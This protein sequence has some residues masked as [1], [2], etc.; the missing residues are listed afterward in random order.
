MAGDILRTVNGGYNKADVLSK[1]DAYTVLIMT[2]DENLM[3]D[4]AVNAELLRIKEMPLRQNKKGMIFSKSGLATT[5]L[6]VITKGFPLMSVN[7]EHTSNKCSKSSQEAIV[8]TC[9][10][11]CFPNLTPFETSSS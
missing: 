11:P 7:D 10:K 2:I 1:I 5:A 8:S 3:S 6:A 9:S 4:A